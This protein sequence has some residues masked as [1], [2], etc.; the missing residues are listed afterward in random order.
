MVLAG[1]I[2]ALWALALVLTRRKPAQAHV[3]T[4]MM[5]WEEKPV[6]TLVYFNTPLFWLCI[7]S[8]LQTF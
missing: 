8:I 6:V 4:D 7:L 3:S 5:A 2:R 1:V